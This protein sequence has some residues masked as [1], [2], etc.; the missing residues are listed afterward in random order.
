VYHRDYAQVIS[1]Q[2]EQLKTSKEQPNRF[3]C[4]FAHMA[5]ITLADGRT[6][7][8]SVH[9][10]RLWVNGLAVAATVEPVDTTLVRVTLPSGKVF[11][12]IRRS[13]VETDTYTTAKASVNGKA[14]IATVE[15]QHQ[16]LL[17]KMGRSGA[18]NQKVRDVKAP[19]PGLIRR[20]TVAPG[21]TVA[22]GEALLVLEAMKMENILKS[23]ADG[24][25]A[26]VRV[27][28]GQA[29]GKNDILLRFS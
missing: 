18:G 21:Q 4:N 22:K 12:V 10:G 23:P 24:V 19:M 20:I 1:V 8:V 27:T 9:E 14:A 3:C 26:E 2:G 25:V 6:F 11:E 5:R 7:E 16:L 15:S 13:T 17:K 29:V 28:E